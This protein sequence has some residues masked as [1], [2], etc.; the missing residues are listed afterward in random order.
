MKRATDQP[1]LSEWFGVAVR[2]GFA[3][4]VILGASGCSASE[5]LITA[6]GNIGVRPLDAGGLMDAS[7]DSEVRPDV[8]DADASNPDESTQLIELRAGQPTPF[9]WGVRTADSP[10]F[11]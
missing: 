2:V 3:G 4:L 1:E 11:M 10:R 9:S 7:T 6:N 8:S 5:D